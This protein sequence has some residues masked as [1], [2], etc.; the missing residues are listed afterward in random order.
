MGIPLSIFY[1]IY[2]VLVLVYLAYTFF[3]VYHLLRFGQLSI[4]T[5]AVCVFYIAG[6]V[7]VLLFT[8]QSISGINWNQTLPILPD[9][10]TLK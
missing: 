7:V 1:F 10:T 5:F 3:N 9:M 4:A 6:S 2:L 8:W